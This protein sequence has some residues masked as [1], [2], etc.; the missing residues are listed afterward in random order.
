MEDGGLCGTLRPKFPDFGRLPQSEYTLISIDP[1][2]MTETKAIFSIVVG[3]AAIYFGFTVKQFYAARGMY[4]GGSG[5]PIARWKGRLLFVV[6]G[7]GFL[8]IGLSYF[9]YDV[10][11]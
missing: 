3:C 6:V 9:F 7:I 10:F 8:L 2:P 5:P 11:R 1:M 4:G